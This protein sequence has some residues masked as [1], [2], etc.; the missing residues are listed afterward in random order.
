MKG[1][2]MTIR[3]D[4]D[5][6]ASLTKTLPLLGYQKYYQKAEYGYCRGSEPIEYVK[7][8]MIYYDI[9]RHQGIEYHT[10]LAP[11]YHFS[12]QSS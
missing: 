12:Y 8:I 6:W 7:Q 9:L 2:D 5:K 1:K 3:L 11:L 10:D 4:P